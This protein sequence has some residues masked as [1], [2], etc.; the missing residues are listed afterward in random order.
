MLGGTIDAA[1]V[2]QTQPASAAYALYAST[3]GIDAVIINIVAIV[4]IIIIIVIILIVAIVIIDNTM[5]ITFPSSLD[6]QNVCL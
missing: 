2:S 5:S 6:R 4:I 1:G 3:L